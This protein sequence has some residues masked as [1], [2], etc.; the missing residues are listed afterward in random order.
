MR[1]K[2]AFR[3]NMDKEKL[4]KKPEIT[5]PIE[6]SDFGIP[7][8]LEIASDNIDKIAVNE[9]SNKEIAEIKKSIQIGENSKKQE[10]EKETELKKLVTDC[11]RQL[12]LG[13]PDDIQRDEIKNRLIELAKINEEKFDEID[14]AADNLRDKIALLIEKKLLDANIAFDIEK[15]LKLIFEDKDSLMFCS[16]EAKRLTDELLVKIGNK[17]F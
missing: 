13:K 11:F 1:P 16:Q 2:G 4:N 3:V 10:S 15:W 7:K 8:N 6:K 12:I 17:K 5:K 14:L 9:P